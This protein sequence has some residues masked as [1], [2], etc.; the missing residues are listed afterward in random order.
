[1]ILIFNLIYIIRQPHNRGSGAISALCIAISGIAMCGMIFN[2]CFFYTIKGRDEI[3]L[4][5]SPP[6]VSHFSAT[7]SPS[8]ASPLTGYIS[9]NAVFVR[10]T[11]SY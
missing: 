2:D 7:T 11:L 3:A 1:M 10:V 5:R 9:A 4:R 6:S 8:F